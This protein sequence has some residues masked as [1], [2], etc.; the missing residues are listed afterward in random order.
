MPDLIIDLDLSAEKMLAYYRGEVRSVRV[1]ATNGQTVQ[2]P[3]SVL[4]KHIAADG[5]HGR[6]RMEFDNQNKFVRLERIESEGA[7][8]DAV[9]AKKPEP[10]SWKARCLCRQSAC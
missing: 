6:Y 8:I 5:I 1:R 2:F 10:K 7:E 9:I 4:Q 3:V